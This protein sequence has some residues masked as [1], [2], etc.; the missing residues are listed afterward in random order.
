MSWSGILRPQGPDTS[1]PWFKDPTINSILALPVRGVGVQ[2]F[3]PLSWSSPKPT[4]SLRRQITHANHT[5]HRC[6]SQ[7]LSPG[8]WSPWSSMSWCLQGP[9][10]FFLPKLPSQASLLTMVRRCTQPPCWVTPPHTWKQ[11]PSPKSSLKTLEL[12]K[13]LLQLKGPCLGS[14]HSQRMIWTGDH[15]AQSH[16]TQKRASPGPAAPAAGLPLILLPQKLRET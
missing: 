3:K 13:R 10:A 5:P 9:P 7:G 15:L 16:P 8:T 12:E 2:L 1:L 11:P 14:A 6:T 4:A